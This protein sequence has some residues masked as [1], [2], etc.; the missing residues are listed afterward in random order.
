[1]TLYQFKFPD[2]EKNIEKA[3]DEKTV[4]KMFNGYNKLIARK[5]PKV[6]ND[7]FLK[8]RDIVKEKSIFDYKLEFVVF[9]NSFSQPAQDALESQIEE[10]K[11][12][13]GNLINYKVV[14]HKNICDIYDRMQKKSRIDIAMT[15]RKLDPSYNLGEDVK[16][17]VGFLSAKELIESCKEQMDVIF[18]ENI[19]LYEGDNDVNTG[20]YNTAIGD[21]SSKFFFYHN[22]IVFI[23]DSCKNSTGN[24]NLILE[25]ASV[26][27]GCQTINSLKKAY[28]E[29][30]IKD[31]VYLQFRVIETTDFDLRAKITEFLNSQTQIRDSYFL[32]NNTFVRALQIELEEKGYFLERLINE[33]EYKRALNKVKE[34]EKKKILKLEKIVQI[35]AA[36]YHNEYAARAKRGKGELFDKTTVEVL[37]SGIDAEKVI[38]SYEWYEKICRVLTIY[39]KCRRSSSVR[40]DFFEYLDF[41]VEED[42]YYKEMDKYAFLNTGDLLL[43]NTISN[44]EKRCV[45]DSKEE[46]VIEAIKIAKNAVL[47]SG[48]LPSQATKNNTIFTTIQS[49]I[50]TY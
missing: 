37:V 48:L 7:I 36:F 10:I 50:N 15:Y 38:H 19:R 28:D 42:S 24:Q 13:T 14:Q 34:Y 29:E 11:D 39:R 5:N 23:C 35:Y 2:R 41:D 30:K 8:Y 27:N 18:D 46:Y 16:S 31:D 47:N 25:G 40:M 22:G 17:F 26:V 20:I 6:G 32:A 45:Y 33:Y 3:I 12:K 21:E 43:L 9:N 4:L 44:L 1:M 49:E